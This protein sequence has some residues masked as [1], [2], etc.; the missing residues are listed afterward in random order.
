MALTCIKKGV[1]YQEFAASIFSAHTATHSTSESAHLIHIFLINDSKT[2][3]PPNSYFI[4]TFS[5]I[6]PTK[7]QSGA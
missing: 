5:Y 3:S 6:S 2:K 1:L 7:N 4:N